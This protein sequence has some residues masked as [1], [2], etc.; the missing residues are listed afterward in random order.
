MQT[1]QAQDDTQA[2]TERRDRLGLT[3]GPNEGRPPLGS[4][5]RLYTLVLANAV[6]IMLLIAAFSAYRF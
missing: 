5:P 1:D 3:E 6:A 4:W 2:A